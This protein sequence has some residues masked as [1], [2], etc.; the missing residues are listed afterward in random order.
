[1]SKILAIVASP[2]KDG[3]CMAIVNAITDGA[4]GLSP[5]VL[6]I[7]DLNALRFTNGCQACMGCKLTGSCVTKD[8]LLPIL[9]LVRDADSLIVATP[10]YFGHSS[11]QYRMLEDRLYSFIDKD[12]SSLLPKGKKLVTVVTCGGDSKAAEAVAG[13]IERVYAD[14]FSFRPV[15]RIVLADKG[16]K[17]AAENNDALMDE[18]RALGKK[19]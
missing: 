9:G 7:I 16:S 8:D 1:M 4:M 2:R 19:L 14:Y 12:G 10:V 6:D 11:S 18:A 15:G 3:N 5:N 13:E 17:H